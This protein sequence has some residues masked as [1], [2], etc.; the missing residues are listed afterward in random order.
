MTQLSAT[1]LDATAGVDTAVVAFIYLEARLADAQ[2][3]EGLEL[4]RDRFAP[5]LLEE[6]LSH[7][8]ET[9]RLDGDQVVI[10]HT[11]TE[12]RVT[13]LNLYLR[14]ADPA[15]ARAA[16]VDFGFAIKDLAS[17]NI[18]PGDMLTKNFGVTRHGRV[19]FYDYDEICLL[20]ECNFR[21]LPTARDDAE[22]WASEPWFHVGERDVFPEEFW[23]FMAFPG[24]L[25]EAFVERHADLLTLE[26]WEEMQARAAG[27]DLEAPRPYRD[28]RRL[29]NPG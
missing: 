25:G 14:A 10:R 1:A 28:E 5:G 3:F 6:L 29:R 23:T 19:V 26:Y 17:V 18:F 2:E 9:V 20:T 16:V 24:A 22:E 7:A 4:F 27:G 12:R 21:R 13:P 15:A 8:G 11:Y